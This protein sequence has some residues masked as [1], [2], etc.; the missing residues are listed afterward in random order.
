MG[1]GRKRLIAGNWKMNCQ[2][3]AA[4]ELASSVVELSQASENAD[5]LICV[6]SIHLADIEKCLQDSQ[7]KLGAQ[8]A[9]WAESGAY[10]GETSVSMLEDYRVQYLLVG[11]SERR[12]MFGDSDERVANKFEAALKNGIKPI[13]CIGESLEQREQGVTLD[14]LKSQVQAVIDRVGIKAFENAAIAYEPIWAIGTGVTA[15]PEQAQEVHEQ[16]RHW[17]ATH[18]QAIAD[19]LQILYGGSMNAANAE[20]LLAQP[21]I[22]GGL[23]GGASLKADD[24]MKI[25]SVA[26]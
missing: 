21:D 7:V 6:P 1:T 10:T 17:L 8:D 20:T 26:R 25:Y 2:R 24:F 23:I 19:G 13:L 15:T 4:L 9:H 11:H 5:L 22:D 14:V 16:L 12:E 3:A 18:D